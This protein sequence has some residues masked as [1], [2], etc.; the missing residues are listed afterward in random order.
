MDYSLL[1]TCLAVYRSGSLTKAARLLGISQPAVT[2]QIRS[3]EGILGQTLFTRVAKGT[4][5]TDAAHELVRDTA[6]ALDALEVAITRRT[7]P[8]SLTDRTIHL[9]GPSEALSLRVLPA[10]SDLIAAGLRLR[11]TF[12]LTDDLVGGLAEGH[13]DMVVSTRLDRSPGITS[14]PLMD[15]EFA[16]V[17]SRE[18][19]VKLPDDLIT[20]DGAAA[21]LCA[22]LISYAESLP[23]I[24]RYWH[25]VFG[26]SPS[27]TPQVTAPD[28][29]A[30]LGAVRA[31]AG[32]SVLPTYLC[33]ADLG[34]GDVKVL[35]HP[36]VAPLNTL[37]L[38]T[39]STGALSHT[40]NAVRAQ[41]VA[42]ARHW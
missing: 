38:A 31:G 22:P 25:T 34:S 5:P 9:A 7:R 1:A 40:I 41:L 16:L 42:Q 20:R 14:T 32:I 29:R 37:Y 13:F 2:G 8:R 15:E 21:L 24:R 23:I 17:G 26:H 35:H 6:D 10:L 30:V 11:L 28:L 19:A 3:L 36:K 39:R 27:V 12:G 4:V 33:S 18:W